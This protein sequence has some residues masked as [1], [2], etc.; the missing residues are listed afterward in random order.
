MTLRFGGKLFSLKNIEKGVV[1]A[2]VGG[3]FV[4][5]RDRWDGRRL[6]MEP[7]H[8]SSCSTLALVRTILGRLE[9][10]GVRLRHTVGSESDLVE[11]M[12]DLLRYVLRFFIRGREGERVAFARVWGTFSR[13][14]GPL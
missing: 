3:K 11:R 10:C 9:A 2:G 14:F 4:E 12:F 8:L 5:H 6:P 7:F 1:G 13:L